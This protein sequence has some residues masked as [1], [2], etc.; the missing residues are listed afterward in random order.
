MHGIMICLD[1]ART[2]AHAAAENDKVNQSLDLINDGTTA[3]AHDIPGPADKTGTSPQSTRQQT[4]S[5]ASLRSFEIV[6]TIS[7]HFNPSSAF[8]NRLLVGSLNENKKATE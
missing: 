3:H 6:S 7:S 2:T 4:S 8:A 5:Y 1:T